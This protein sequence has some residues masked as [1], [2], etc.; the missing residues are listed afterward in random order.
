[1]M[2]REPEAQGRDPDT[3]KALL[4]ETLSITVRTVAMVHY[5]AFH[6]T[7][8]CVIKCDLS[9]LGFVTEALVTG[10]GIHDRRKQR[11][12]RRLK[13]NQINQICFNN[14]KL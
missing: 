14:V 5:T 7:Y 11:Q 1:M 4:N 10:H 12:H 2:S 13:S 9:W 6:R 3:C 8:S